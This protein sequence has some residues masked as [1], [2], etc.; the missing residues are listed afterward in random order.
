MLYCDIPIE[1]YVVGGMAYTTQTLTDIF[2][3]IEFCRLF[4]LLY[5]FD[6]SNN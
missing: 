4:E 3:C 1:W 5:Q 6:M 2:I